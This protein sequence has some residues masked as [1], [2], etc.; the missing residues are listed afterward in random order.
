M[1]LPRLSMDAR[2]RRV[3]VQAAGRWPLSRGAAGAGRGDAGDG[4][5]EALLRQVRHQ[6]TEATTLD[7]EQVGVLRGEGVDEVGEHARVGLG[8]EV[9]IVDMT[10]DDLPLFA[11]PMARR[12]DHDSSHVAADRL[13]ASGA[14]WRQREEALTVARS[15]DIWINRKACKLANAI[16]EW[17][18]G[19]TAEENAVMLN[20]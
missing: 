15:L 5:R 10:D 11:H 1:E 2:A 12:T 3:P 4:D 18:E 13:E 16:W 19:S 6:V 20:H 7:A 9:P 8:G 14:A 17:E